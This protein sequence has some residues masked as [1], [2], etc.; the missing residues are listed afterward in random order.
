MR[1]KTID[2][3]K[4]MGMLFIVTG[5][6]LAPDSIFRWYL[7]SFHVPLFLFLSGLMFNDK[8]WNKFLPFFKARLRT[9]MWP[10][11]IFTIIISFISSLSLKDFDLNSLKES[12][13]GALWFLPILFVCELIYYPITKIRVEYRP[14]LLYII[15]IFSV[16]ASPPT[17]MP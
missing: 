14:I 16:C 9:I 12:L 1:S 10:C 13:P 6:C 3:A 2:M 5:H 7:S 8:K 4:G 15:V 11:L 17:H